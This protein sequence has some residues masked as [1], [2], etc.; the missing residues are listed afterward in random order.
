MK[1]YIISLFYIQIILTFLQNIFSI[2]PKRD[3]YLTGHTDTVLSFLLLK[4][5]RLA[6]SSSDNTIRIWSLLSFKTEIILKGHSDYI[7]K[8]IQLNDNKIASCSDDMTIRIWDLQ[9]QSTESVIREEYIIDTINELTD[10]RIVFSFN[11]TI[12]ILDLKNNIRQKL[13]GHTEEVYRIIQL[14]DGRI[15]SCSL[16]KTIRIWNL[17]TNKSEKILTGHPSPLRELIELKDGRLCVCS[18]DSFISEIWIWNLI[19]YKTDLVIK[20]KCR[21]IYQLKDS[22]L[23]ISTGNSDK[24]SPFYIY[25]LLTYLPAT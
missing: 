17:T 13:E 22:R 5:G 10:G 8:I 20:E 7:Y 21:R 4:D 1:S 9:T 15:A 12:T 2:P 23:A 18:S 11:K 24:D 19:N 25:N 6:S 3:L 14:K 16:D